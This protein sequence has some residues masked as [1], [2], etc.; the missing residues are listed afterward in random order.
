[1]LAGAPRKTAGKA[2][3]CG[4][5]AFLAL[6]LGPAATASAAEDPEVLQKQGIRRINQ[7]IEHFRQTGDRTTLLPQL[8]Q[9][10]S[11]LAASYDAFVARQDF[12]K[13]A[14]SLFNIGDAERMQNH[15]DN[16]RK[17]YLKA[18]DTAQQGHDTAC[19]AKALM[20]LAKSEVN[21]NGNLGAAAEY[22]AEALRLASASGSKDVEA[23]AYDIASQVAVKQGNLNAAADYLNRELEFEGQLQDKSRIFYGYLGR[24]DVYLQRGE[25]CDYKR[26]YEVCYQALD[27]S[28]ADYL[29]ARDLAHELGYTFLASQMEDF[30]KEVDARERLLKGQEQFQRY[31]IN[32]FIDPKKASDVLVSTHFAPP[33]DPATGAT[34]RNIAQQYIGASD[35]GDPRGA[36]IEAKLQEIEGHPDAA[37][38]AYQKAVDLL[39]RDRRNLKDDQDR[40]KFLE[41]KINLYYDP[42]LLLL[43]KQRFGDAFKL[44]EQSRSRAMTDLLESKKVTL[45]TPVEREFFSESLRLKANI[46]QLQHKLFGLTGAESQKNA[47]EISRLEGQIASLDGQSQQLSAR[48]EREAPKLG[49]LMVSEPVTLANAQLAAGQGNYDLLYYLVLE[50]AVVVW[51]IGG[52]AVEARSV[53]LPRSIESDKVKKLRGSLVN[54]AQDPETKFDEATSRGLYLL[55]IEPMTKFVKTRH[56]VIVPH[57]DLNYLPFQVLENPADGS[58]LGEKFEISYAPSATVL[59]SLKRKPNL[60]AERLIAIANPGMVDAAQEVEA[61]GKLY[62]RRSRVV[63]EVFARK[64]DVKAWVGDYTLVHLSVDGSFNAADPLLSFLELRPTAQDDGHLTAAEMFGLPLGGASLVVL[65]ACET[66]IVEATHANEL[67]GMQRALLYAGANE[68]VLSSWK[69][70]A[71]AT[72]LWMETFYREAQTKTPSEAARLA[73]ITVR[74]RPEY[75]HPYFWAPFLMTGK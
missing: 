67:L 75:R 51:H 14:L 6:S 31:V 65:S 9:A 37:L 12:A 28:R 73:L 69:V 61:I 45:G 21:S 18:R 64:E 49:S 8:A 40:G 4:A 50:T 24:A 17:V 55:L 66:G 57:E 62:P 44:M 27:R 25:Q 74:S 22:T 29:R 34:L 30:A 16:A 42:I 63:D 39:E 46:A 48:M 72:R 20:G 33:P 54:R 15:W 36:Y 26:D 32:K 60:A 2:F 68:L 5:I 47:A 53:F 38:V 52:D 10:E 19:Q 59:A 11:E 71:D 58:F 35:M 56:L 1:M 70:R 41:D 7:F 13:A 3:L 43:D 23:D